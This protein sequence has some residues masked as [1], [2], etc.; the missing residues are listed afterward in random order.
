MYLKFRNCFHLWLALNV[1]KT[2]DL[3]EFFFCQIVLL[4]H[5]ASICPQYLS[6]SSSLVL[7]LHISIWTQAIGIKT[8]FSGCHTLEL[9]VMVTKFLYK[10]SRKFL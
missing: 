9:D 2:G 7:G 4:P 10:T 6:S 8:A 1:N 5:V 3:G